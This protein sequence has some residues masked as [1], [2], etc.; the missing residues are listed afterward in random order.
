LQAEKGDKSPEHILRP[1]GKIDDAQ[2]AENDGKAERQQ[3]IKRAVDQADQQLPEQG[4][5]WNAED[6]RHR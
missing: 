3:R 2:Q 1:M 5:N 6:H 4:L